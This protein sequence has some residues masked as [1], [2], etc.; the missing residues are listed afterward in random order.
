MDLNLDTLKR[1]ILEYLAEGGFAVFHS[2]PGGLEGM[3]MVLWD[4]EKYPDYQMFLAA[5]KKVNVGLIVFAAREFDAAVS[6]FSRASEFDKPSALFLK[7]TEELAKSPPNAD[8]E[9]VN[10][11]DPL[12]GV[13]HSQQDVMVQKVKTP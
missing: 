7:R 6:C 13:T 8:W 3:P 4:S 10:A 11:L 9:P 5:A 2:S 12:S 1:E